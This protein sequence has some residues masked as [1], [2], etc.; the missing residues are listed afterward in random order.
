VKCAVAPPE[1]D[2]EVA[3]EIVA[4]PPDTGTRERGKGFVVGRGPC[5]VGEEPLQ[6]LLHRRQVRQVDSAQ[7]VAREVRDRDRC[8]SAR[9]N[10]TP[11][12][13]TGFVRHHPSPYAPPAQIG[14]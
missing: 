7:R 6:E 10:L 14:S 12:I 13:V 3:V 9:G 1:L 2:T 5:S 8:Q 4:P 11:S